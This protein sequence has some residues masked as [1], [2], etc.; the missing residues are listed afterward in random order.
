M[1]GLK[2]IVYPG[3]DFGFYKFS[4]EGY[5]AIAVL[6]RKREVHLNFSFFDECSQCIKFSSEEIIP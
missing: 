2:A 3:F 5:I 4:R 1:I 6:E